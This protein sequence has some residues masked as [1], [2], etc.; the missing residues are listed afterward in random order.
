MRWFVKSVLS[1][2]KGGVAIQIGVGLGALVGM[3]GLGTESTF[4]IYKHRQMQ[5]VTN[6][7]AL[8]GAMALSQAWPRDPVS[9]AR[10]VTARLGYLHGA[11]Q[12]TITVNTPPAMGPYVGNQG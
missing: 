12:V 2:T 10:A 7:A 9:E 6:S 5:S 4:L 8:S 1:S 3:L 11:N